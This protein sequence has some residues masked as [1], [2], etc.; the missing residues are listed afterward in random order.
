MRPIL[1]LQL[2]NDRYG[3]PALYVDFMF[4]KRAFLLDLG[5]VHRLPPKKILRLTDIFVTHT[6]MDHFIGF[7]QILRIFLGREAHLRLWGP[8]GFIQQVERKLA[9]YTWNLT[10]RY[11]VSLGITVSEVLSE[12]EMRQARFESRSGFTREKERPIL[13][14]DG[15]IYQDETLRVRTAILDHGIPCLGFMIEEKEHVNVWKDRLQAKGLTVGPWLRELKR[16]LINK[17]PADTVI[18]ALVLEERGGGE[19]E[20]LLKDLKNDVA[21]IVPGQKVGYVVDILY[22]EANA[23]KVANLVRGADILYIEAPFLKVEEE[24]ARD[25]CHLT[26]RQ[27]GLLARRADVKRVEAFHFSPK[28]MDEEAKLF[29]EVL[30]VFESNKTIAS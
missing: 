8:C 26:T 15:V 3:D 17:L 13:I 5:D 14:S 20:I 12:Q 6:H 25:R 2:V 9:S 30:E 28:H 23:Q 1:H 21:K 22:S 27:A 24:R 4:E 16:A 10:H 7:D 29:A 19:A 18:R 11:Q